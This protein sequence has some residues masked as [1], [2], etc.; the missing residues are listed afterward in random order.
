MGPLG[1]GAVGGGARV[2]HIGDVARVGVV[3]TVGHSLDA[4]VGESDVVLALGG[5]AI[6]SL[7]LGKVGAG[8]VVVDG[9]GILV[10]G[11]GIRG[12]AGAVGGR[13]AGGGGKGGSEDRG[14]DDEALK[15]KP[16]ENLSENVVVYQVNTFPHLH[17]WLMCCFVARMRN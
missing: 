17:G 16:I 14:E 1:G 3:H 6:T 5:I 9:V 7:V 11:G 4:A 15:E 2:G 12:V 10:D 13:G 8:V